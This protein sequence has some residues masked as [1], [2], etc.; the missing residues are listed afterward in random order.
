[1]ADGCWMLITTFNGL[2]AIK[3]KIKVKVK[4]KIKVK[5]KLEI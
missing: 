4:S 2:A 1:M 3:V 5:I